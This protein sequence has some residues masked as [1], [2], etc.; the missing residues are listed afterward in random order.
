MKTTPLY[1]AGSTKALLAE[2]QARIDQYQAE[3]DAED[4]VSTPE[5]PDDEL[6]RQR[7]KRD[8]IRGGA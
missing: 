8:Q 5:P 3:F 4:G 6:A 2:A 7:A 1:A